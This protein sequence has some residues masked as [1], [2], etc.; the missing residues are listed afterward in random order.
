MQPFQEHLAAQKQKW[1]KVG[2]VFRHDVRMEKV[3][4]APAEG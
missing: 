1:V 4:V 2:K 3:H